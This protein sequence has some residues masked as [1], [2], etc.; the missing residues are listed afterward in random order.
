[1]SSTS[2]CTLPSPL[3]N[4]KQT[5]VTEG[6][7]ANVSQPPWCVITWGTCFSI[8][9][10]FQNKW[11]I[12]CCAINR[13]REKKNTNASHLGKHLPGSLKW[14]HQS[15]NGFAGRWNGGASHK[16]VSSITASISKLRKWARADWPSQ[17]LA[18]AGTN[19]IKLLS[20]ISSVKT[21]E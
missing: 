12:L 17:P 10:L 19:I 4:V 1:M 21:V 14:F 18:S 20:I 3:H 15:Q 8:A 6:G 7:I 2:L 13:K 5:R 16:M 11:I 9:S